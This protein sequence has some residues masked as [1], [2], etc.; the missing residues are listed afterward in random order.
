VYHHFVKL[1]FGLT[2]RDV[3]CDFRL[4]RKSVFEKVVLTR[5]SGVICVELMKKLTDHGFRIGEVGVH[6]YHRTY[7][8]SQFFNFPRVA[9]TLRDLAL[10][11]Y[12]L[13]VAR[14]HLRARA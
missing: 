12:E 3:D 11:W 1:A 8:K 7:G 14:V 6:H 4:M 2:V 10:L 13:Q 9:R 5:S